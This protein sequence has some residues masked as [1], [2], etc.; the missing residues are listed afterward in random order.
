VIAAPTGVIYQHQCA[1]IACEVRQ[2]EGY[3]VPLGGLKFDADAGAIN[4]AEFTALFHAGENCAWGMSGAAFPAD[5]LSGLRSLV[6]SVTFWD[7]G[8]DGEVTARTHLHLDESRLSE[9][10]EAW[11]PVVTPAG[12]GILMWNNCD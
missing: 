4:P 7:I 3:L 2:V 10:A 1:G 11:V 6:G 8:E 9:Q 12:R 5:R